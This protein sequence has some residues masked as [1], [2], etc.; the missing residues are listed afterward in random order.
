VETS[1]SPEALVRLIN[2]EFPQQQGVRPKITAD[3]PA[4]ASQ[5]T[6]RPIGS[7]TEPE[8][9]DELRP[10]RPV[11]VS[12]SSKPGLGQRF[13]SLL[14]LAAGLAAIVAMASVGLYMLVH[15]LVPFSAEKL[16]A[17][18][19][20]T[21]KASAPILN[22]FAKAAE[23][24][25]AAAIAMP[26]AVAP[27]PALEFSSTNPMPQPPAEAAP[28]IAVAPG[29]LALG[30]A[31]GIAVPAPAVPPEEAT[32]IIA[33]A[34]RTAPAVA[35]PAPEVPPE[36]ATPTVA[37]APGTASAVA[38]PAPAAPP[39]EATPI[40]AVAPGALALDKAPVVATPGSA[41]SPEVG[42]TLAMAALAAPPEQLRPPTAPI[43]ALVARGD[44]LF[45]VGDV[46]SARLFYRRASDAGDAQA[47]LKLGETYDPSFLALARLNG[48][49][50][51]LAVA[52]QWY[53]R[54]RDLGASEAEIL[55]RSVGDR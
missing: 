28:I 19:S 35:M 3:K 8:G 22:A 6:D 26:S 24:T 55:L 11:E 37:L 46:A 44:S 49:R 13:A 40:V 39:E 38:M 7:G 51:D 18:T 31:P 27:E 30:T 25:P 20:P 53:R 14:S 2:I 54:A 23:D 52:T 41:I 47:A 33:L 15:L 32:P 4:P 9:L 5:S 16:A 36:E 21:L 34:P 45:G 50:G 12:Q 43:S 17:T 10:I 1:L 29:A 48:V 42:Q